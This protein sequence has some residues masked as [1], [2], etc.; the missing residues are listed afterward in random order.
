M[1]FLKTSIALPIKFISSGQFISE[2]P[3]NHTKRV[4]DSFELLIGV[5]ETLYIE[6]GS[7]RYELKPGHI[8]LL[9]PGRLHQGYAESNKNLNFYWCHFY[10]QGYY[11]MVDFDEMR[12]QFS[13]NYSDTNSKNYN[14]EVYIP[15]YYVPPSI[16]RINILF[17]Q[18]QHVANANYYTSQSAHYLITTILI[19]ISQQAI[20]SFFRLDNKQSK[21]VNISKIQEW[22]RAHIMNDISV[23]EVAQ[24]FNYNKDYLSRVFKQKTGVNLSDFIQEKKISKS[25]EMLTNTTMSVKEI[26]QILSF[27]DDKYFMKLFKK[28]EKMTPTEFRN[29]FYKSHINNR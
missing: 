22:I 14:T 28:D 1:Q 2:Q 29:A 10:C 24:K 19:E 8:L 3:W 15:I 12:K 7:D 5:K 6:Q 11:E 23:S 26:S 13:I 18:L 16:D 17:N 20:T 4:N 25:K 9:S 21:N 27:N